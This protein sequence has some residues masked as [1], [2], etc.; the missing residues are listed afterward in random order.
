VIRKYGE[1]SRRLQSLR[2]SFSRLK[3]PA[4]SSSDT[5]N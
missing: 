2:S 3:I 1:V 4:A 5:T